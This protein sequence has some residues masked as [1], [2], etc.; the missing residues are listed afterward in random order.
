MPFSPQVC[1]HF[2]LRLDLTARSSILVTAA[3]GEDI[4][5]TAVGMEE[6]AFHSTFEVREE[7]TASADLPHLSS[8]LPVADV[9]ID[10]SSTLPLG[11]E[12][13]EHRPPDAIVLEHSAVSHTPS[14]DV[15]VP[16]S[17]TPG[18]PI[19]MLF[20]LNSAVVLSEHAVLSL[21]YHSQ[22]PEPAAS[23]LSRSWDL[24]AAVEG[25]D[26]VKAALGL[27]PTS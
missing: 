19:G 26:N 23:G 17:P 27:A 8:P 13:I 3:E 12:H 1:C 9:V 16:S 20:P 2:R 5:K 24:S 21:E 10:D 7:I 11:T 14:S 4:T 18:L 15:E 6:D 22:M 25:E